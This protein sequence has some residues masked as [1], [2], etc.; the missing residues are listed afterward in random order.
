[1]SYL[2]SVVIPTKNRYDYLIECIQSLLKFDVQKVEIVISDNSDDNQP[3]LDVFEKTINECPNLKYYY[4]KEKLS[5][6]GNSN[7]AFEHATGKYCCYIGDDDSLALAALDY[8]EYID[9]KGIE[10]AVCDVAT[11]HW[12]DVVFEGKA[13]PYFS[14]RKNPLD[15]KELIP[16]D[17]VNEVLSCGIQDIKFLARVYHGIISFG[18]LNR[19]KD[20]TGSY[21][22]GPSPDMAN[23]MACTLMLS[24]Y[25]YI[26]QPLVISGYSYKSAGGMGLRGAHSGKLSQ[27]KQLSSDVEEKWTVGIPKLWLGYTMWLESG[28]KA[29]EALNEKKLSG[30]ANFFAMYAKTWLKYPQYRKDVLSFISGPSAY[31]KFFYECIKFMLR[32]T[33]EKRERTVLLEKDRIYQSFDKMSLTESC[34]I[35]NNFLISN[36]DDIIYF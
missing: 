21:F 27:A 34:T 33:K 36:T 11:Y 23:A 32:Y 24:K 10:A 29:L 2:L 5:Q 35:T 28:L 25:V 22:P 7:V 3:F 14:Y 31:M 16:L 30:K 19:V 26:N 17:V 13:K 18:I 12:P 15:I 6:T 4:T 1:M 20:L 8:V 9:K